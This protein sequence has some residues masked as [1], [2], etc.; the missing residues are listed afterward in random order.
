M[1]EINNPKKPNVVTTIFWL[2]ILDLVI[3]IAIMSIDSIRDIFRDYMQYI[4]PLLA[5]I[6]GVLG[7]ILWISAKKKIT[8]KK[9]RRFLILT[10]VC[11]IGF[12][13]F[14]LLHNVFYGI[15]TVIS[16]LTV[17]SYIVSALEIIFFLISIFIC[18]PGFLIGVIGSI[19]LL[20]KKH[21]QP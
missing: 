17:L 13:A 1:K 21:S 8:E 7:I 11:A 3:L 20:H 4:F 9:L 14:T 19:I 6:F 15:N 2:L 16:H 18:P 10:G 12:F 5:G